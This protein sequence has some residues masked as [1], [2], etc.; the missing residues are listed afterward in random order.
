MIYVTAGAG[1]VGPAI[2]GHLVK[3]GQR[4]RVLVT[5]PGEGKSV[6]GA[7]VEVVTGDRRKPETFA[8]T[9]E[10]IEAAVLLTR[11]ALDVP[12]LDGNFCK[13][14]KAA[15]VRRVAKI[16][17]FNADVNAAP[18]AKRTHALAEEAVKQSG[19]G[20]T[21]VRPQFF[22]QNILWFADEIKAKG[23]FSLPMGSG[24]VGM[25]DFRDVAAVAAK[26]AVEA[27]H[28][29]KT[30]NLSGPA[31][32]SPQDIAADLT[33]ALGRE[34]R[35]ND[36]PAEEFKR[37]LMSMGRPEWHADDMT[38]S[39]VAMS[40]GAS[41]FLADGVKRVLGREA[42]PFSQVARDYAHHFR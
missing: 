40:K 18:G 26:C 36:M 9:L 30:Y 38:R 37:L 3:S 13:A 19:I 32:I 17:A 20:W 34:I 14:A 6:E 10:G 1:H 41:A 28:E 16:S 33:R 24:R 15:G 2:V 11:N 42:T 39:Y 23:T 5:T 12:E 7:G 31:L 25:N 4:V 29:G 35:Y 8:R 22:M 27:G 21:F